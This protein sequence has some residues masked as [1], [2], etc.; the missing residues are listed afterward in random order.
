[1]ELYLIRHGESEANLNRTH[2]GWSSVNLTETGRMQAENAR[3][4]LE[5]IHFDKLFVSDIKRAQQTA[6]I[7]FPGMPRTFITIAREMDNTVMDGLT[8]EMMYEK[9]GEKGE[10]YLACRERFDYSPLGIGCESLAHLGARADE[11]LRML[12]KEPEDSRVAVVS[13][14]GFIIA[15]AGR[16]LGLGPHSP[17]LHCNNAAISVF[18][19]LGNRWKLKMWNL[20]PEHP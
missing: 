20:T 15:V 16:I 17:L 10:L 9:M 19:H 14:A 12:E 8:K 13:H 3:R 2:C 4:H 1:M 5:G 7:L 11:L 18:T 6:D